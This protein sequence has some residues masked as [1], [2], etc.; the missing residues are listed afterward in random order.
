[1]KKIFI[2]LVLLLAATAA[3][4][5]PTCYDCLAQICENSLAYPYSTCWAG[6][7]YCLASGDCTATAAES[8]EPWLLA[9]WNLDGVRVSIEVA[10]DG[11]TPRLEPA[12][13][14]THR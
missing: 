12:E 11:T 7:G 13:N 10:T 2:A 8:D 3:S 4:A 5:A 14:P 9:D 1:M 6:P